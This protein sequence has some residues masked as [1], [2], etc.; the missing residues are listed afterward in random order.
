MF[1]KTLVTTY[2]SCAVLCSI[3]GDDDP[4]LFR[5]VSNPTFAVGIDLYW[6]GQVYNLTNSGPPTKVQTLGAVPS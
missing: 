1:S 3:M 2:P 6:H 5:L 4:L